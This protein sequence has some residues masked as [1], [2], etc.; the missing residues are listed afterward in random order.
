MK[1]ISKQEINK[2]YK[3]IAKKAAEC[4]DALID[5]LGNYELK[6]SDNGKIF[7]KLETGEEL[8]SKFRSL[9]DS[10][11]YF[12]VLKDKH[13]YKGIG[14]QLAS[15]GINLTAIKLTNHEDV[16]IVEFVKR[17]YGISRYDERKNTLLD[18]VYYN[19]VVKN[20]TSFE[21]LMNIDFLQKESLLTTEFSAHM[22]SYYIDDNEQKEKASSIYPSHVYFNGKDISHMYKTIDGIDKISIIYNSY[23]DNY[24]NKVIKNEVEQLIGKPMDED[25]I[26]QIIENYV[27][28]E[29]GEYMDLDKELSKRIEGNGILRIKK[30]VK[31]LFKK[32]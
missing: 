27:I 32:I 14:F 13:I 29:S 15:N 11:L 18:I 2:R 9:K 12:S 21:Q 17:L 26:N 1:T 6:M 25:V 23:I 24:R 5:V 7:I 31:E 8:F 28:K 30:R 16:F 19:Y 3:F 22:R 10:F 20:A 4:H